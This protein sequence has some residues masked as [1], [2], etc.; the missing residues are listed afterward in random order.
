MNEVTSFLIIWLPVERRHSNFW[1]VASWSHGPR[2]F[3]RGT[4]SLTARTPSPNYQK[5]GSS[6][7]GH[8]GPP[9]RACP[10]GGMTDKLH[11]NPKNQKEGS[12]PLGHTATF[13]FMPAG[14]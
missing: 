6:P 14:R 1:L 12:L 11:A 13:G 7:L 2:G 9:S 10:G 3:T 5:E 4:E 8:T